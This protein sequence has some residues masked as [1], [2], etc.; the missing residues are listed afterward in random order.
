MTRSVGR[1][2]L[3]GGLLKGSLVAALVPG[4]AAA[5]W[6]TVA[7]ASADAPLRVLDPPNA[8]LVA[9]VADTILP[10]TE[11]P[12]ATDV[13]VVRWIDTV[14][15][16]Y[17]PEAKR[18]EFLDGLVAIDAN[19]VALTGSPLGMLPA[20]AVAGVISGLDAACGRKSLV[21]AERGY[22][23]LKELVVHGYFTS[24]PV[25]KDVLRTVVIPGRFDPSVPL[26]VTP[27]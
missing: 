14:A 13:G 25:Q 11:T 8:R 1:R 22:A 20:G 24:E 16:D 5:A 6:R 12:G 17:L 10:R 21:S 2:E 3:L 26:K 7:A 9:L 4:T 19:A 27:T 15:A 18:R 23:L